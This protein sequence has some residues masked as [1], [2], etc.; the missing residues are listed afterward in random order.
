K[1]RKL[2]MRIKDMLLFAAIAAYTSTSLVQAG[3]HLPGET[4]E[5]GE[6]HLHDNGE[7]AL[8]HADEID[9]HDGP[10]SLPEGSQIAVLEG[11]PTQEGFF[12]ARLKFPADYRIPP[13]T[14][15]RTERVTVLSG[16]FKLGMGREFDEEDTVS[17]SEGAFFTMPA[18]MEHYV[19]TGSETTIQ[20]TGVGPWGIEYVNPED[21]P[22]GIPETVGPIF[23]G[24]RE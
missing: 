2:T 23:G 6:L 1:R 16:E 14:H 22:R 19:Q 13:H 9:W 4:G 7:H 18:G 10:D 20:L 5:E 17:L 15:P 8:Y 12:T 21:D 24:D 3:S 11:D